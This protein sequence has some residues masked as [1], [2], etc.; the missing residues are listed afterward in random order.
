VA[1]DLTAPPHTVRKRSSVEVADGGQRQRRREHRATLLVLP[2]PWEA[3]GKRPCLRQRIRQRVREPPPNDRTGCSRR[4]EPSPRDCHRQR[5]LATDRAYRPRNRPGLG[6]PRVSRPQQVRTK[7]PDMRPYARSTHAM[8]SS[9][10]TYS[11]I[12]R[13]RQQRASTRPRHRLNPRSARR[14]T[15]LADV[16]KPGTVPAVVGLRL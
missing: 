5:G 13:R 11:S 1:T 4:V 15:P 7:T 3:S 8:P 14:P 9:S 16:L 10:C 12:Q 2:L 6:R